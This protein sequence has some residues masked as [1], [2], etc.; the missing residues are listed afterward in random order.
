M[1]SRGLRNLLQKQQI[2][3][4]NIALTSLL[5]ARLTFNYLDANLDA[6]NVDG[7]ARYSGIPLAPVL[8]NG[9]RAATTEDR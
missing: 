9:T 2:L 6:W 3:R 5:L 7:A 8:F 4:L 1:G